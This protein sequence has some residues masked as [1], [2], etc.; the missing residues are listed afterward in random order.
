MLDLQL[1]TEAKLLNLGLH[2]LPGDNLTRS[3]LLAA[4]IQKPPCKFYNTT[5][6]FSD[7]W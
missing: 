7:L 2:I 3:E 6:A 1:P 4:H 5:I